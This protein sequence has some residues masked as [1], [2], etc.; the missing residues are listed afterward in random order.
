MEDRELIEDFLKGDRN[1]FR[2]L[3]SRYQ[4]MVFHTVKSVVLDT[5]DAK[6]ITQQAFIK[7]FQNVRRLKKK[8][9]FKSWLMTVAMNCAKDHLRKKGNECELFENVPDGRQSVEGMIIS[10]DTLRKVKAAI[11]ML[12]P[13]QRMVL[14]LKLFREME[15]AE[16]GEILDIKP[17]TVR[18]NYHFGIQNLLAKLKKEGV[19]YAD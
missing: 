9:R 18:T 10:R 19:Y 16:I 7:A 15:F 6:D 4:R 14:G 3:M 13:R 12:P 2:F 1:A 5:E 11:K 8:D 17:A